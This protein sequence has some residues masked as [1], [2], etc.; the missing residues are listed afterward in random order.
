EGAHSLDSATRECPASGSPQA[1]GNTLHRGLDTASVH[2]VWRGWKP[3]RFA[4]DPI[5]SGRL[6]GHQKAGASRKDR[7]RQ[8]TPA[9]SSETRQRTS[10]VVDDIVSCGIEFAV[11]LADWSGR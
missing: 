9:L 5:A 4:Q 3:D 2:G 7:S 8:A 6:C 11:G 10:T 1:D